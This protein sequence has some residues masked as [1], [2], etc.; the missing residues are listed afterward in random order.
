MP[1]VTGEVVRVWLGHVVHYCEIV[2]LALSILRSS[3]RFVHSSLG[4]SKP[5]PH[6]V[7]QE[8]RICCCLIFL[9]GIDLAYPCP[10]HLYCV[11]ASLSG[12][13]VMASQMTED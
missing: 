11:D 3:Y 13:C 6:S 12:Y 2:R 9:A 5:L 1:K 4:T 8:M 10:D 7:R